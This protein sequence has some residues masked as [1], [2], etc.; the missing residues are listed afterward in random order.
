MLD[1]NDW[2]SGVVHRATIANTYAMR[3]LYDKLSDA[4]S[5]QVGAMSLGKAILFI[6][7]WSRSCS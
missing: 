6:L 3:E 7:A 1:A 2:E 4:Q 5:A